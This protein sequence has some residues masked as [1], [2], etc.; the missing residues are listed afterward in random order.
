M[1]ITAHNCP[2]C[3]KE[4]DGA[5]CLEGDHKPSEGDCTICVYCTSFLKFQADLSFKELTQQEIG[6][7]NGNQRATLVRVRKLCKET[8][9]K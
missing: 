8:F 1:K 6:D 3:K 2:V 7:M 4:L 9:K 5:T